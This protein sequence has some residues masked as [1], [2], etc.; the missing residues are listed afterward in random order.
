MHAGYRKLQDRRLT[1]RRKAGGRAVQGRDLAL[2][3]DY[4]EGEDESMSQRP[5]GETWKNAGEEKEREREEKKK[6]KKK[7]GSGV[8]WNGN[9]EA[10]KKSLGLRRPFGIG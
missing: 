3:G 1:G 2:K 5:R 9:G 6:R 10:S 7:R 4:E 8:E